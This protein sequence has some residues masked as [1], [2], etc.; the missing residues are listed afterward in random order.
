MKMSDVKTLISSG[1]III[2][3][4]LYL[5]FKPDAEDTQVNLDEQI[6]TPAEAVEV[7]GNELKSVQFLSANDGDTFNVMLDD[8]K[9][10]VRLLLVDT[11]EMN[12]DKGEPMPYAE[13][14]KNFTINILE[15]ANKIELLYDVGDERDQYGRLL[16]YVFVDD[17]LLQESLL[18][19]GLAAV[20][21]IHKPNNSLEQQLKEAQNIAASNKVNIW[22]TDDYFKDGLF[23][24]N[25]KDE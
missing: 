14:A 10:R 8:Q 24:E 13:E 25:F 11:P 9:E 18:K 4:A 2:A 6:V 19:E 21:Y 15:N 3:V 23:N 1:V 22:E 12:Y 5:I 17:V 7:T 20:R 16:A